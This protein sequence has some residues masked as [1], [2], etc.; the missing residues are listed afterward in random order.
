MVWFPVQSVADPVSLAALYL[1]V[2]RVL[3]ASLLKFGL[4]DGFKPEYVEYPTQ[5]PVHLHHYHH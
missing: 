4:G 3:I 2:N 1:L 5:A